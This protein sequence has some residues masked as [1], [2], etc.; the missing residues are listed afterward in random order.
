MKNRSS[1]KC[2][3]FEP[4]SNGFCEKNPAKNPIGGMGSPSFCKISQWV[5]VIARSCDFDSL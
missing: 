5:V 1:S 4:V 3:G 2:G